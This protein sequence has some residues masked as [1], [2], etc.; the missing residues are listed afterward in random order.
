VESLLSYALSPFSFSQALLDYFCG[1]FAV[2]CMWEMLSP[3]ISGSGR[4]SPEILSE[5]APGAVVK[6]SNA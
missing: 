6:A 5:N 2:I 4:L 1:E 3:H